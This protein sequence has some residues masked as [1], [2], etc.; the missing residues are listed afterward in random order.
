MTGRRTVKGHYSIVLADAHIR[1]RQQMKKILEE[2]HDL[3][4]SGEAGNRAELLAVLSRSKPE[5]VILDLAMPDLRAREG[6]QLIKSQYPE[7]KILIM[8][9][10]SEKEYLAYGL[11]TGAE[12]VLSKQ[13]VAGDIF[14]AIATIRQGRVYVP[15]RRS[16]GTRNGHFYL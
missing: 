3:K 4:V 8:V 11:A 10:D 2:G 15:V 14:Q 13:Y 5:M 7:I 9:M 1:F 16:G 6:T 12:G